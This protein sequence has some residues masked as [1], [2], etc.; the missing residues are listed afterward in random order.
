MSRCDKMEIEVISLTRK[1][2]FLSSL[3]FGALLVFI[4]AIPLV[5]SYP[6]SDGPNSGPSNA[7]ELVRMIAYDSW[8]LFLIS[9]LVLLIA[10]IWGL[11]GKILNQ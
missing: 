7:W 6:Y 8:A 4:A 5:F 11:R 9:G 3:L 1:V 10:S 2:T